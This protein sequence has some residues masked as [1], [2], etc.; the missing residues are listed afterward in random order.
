[1]SRTVGEIAG[2]VLASIL[3]TF[4]DQPVSFLRIGLEANERYVAML[5][6]RTGKVRNVT[7]F[8]A[9]A[10]DLPYD[11]DAGL[12]DLSEQEDLRVFV[13]KQFNDSFGTVKL[14]WEDKKK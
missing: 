11:E 5:G 4:P 3:G 2:I 8:V 10:L 13:Q 1:M 14:H 12:I 9:R 7:F 6:D